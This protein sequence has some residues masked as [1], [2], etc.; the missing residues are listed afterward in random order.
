MM[1]FDKIEDIRINSRL[2]VKDFLMSIGLSKG[3]YYAIRDG[4]TKVLSMETA[5]K[6]NEK[7]PNYK[8]EWLLEKSN[9]VSQLDLKNNSHDEL[10]FNSVVFLEKDGIKVSI[11]EIAG[12][13]ARNEDAF[14]NDTVFKLWIN[15]LYRDKLK[16]YCDN[17]NIPYTEN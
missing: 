17:H 9:R 8:I 5:I 10:A 12:F 6:I 4:R 7:Y 15:E 14:L 13:I 1:L 16:T 11:E 3:A 2:N